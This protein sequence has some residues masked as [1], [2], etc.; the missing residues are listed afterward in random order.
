LAAAVL[1]C[2]AIYAAGCQ[3]ALTINPSGLNNFDLNAERAAKPM[4]LSAEDYNINLHSLYSD[5]GYVKAVLLSSTSSIDGAVATI[6]GT[7]H[8]ISSEPVTDEYSGLLYTYEDIS[9]AIICNGTANIS[10]SLDGEVLLEVVVEP[11]QIVNADKDWITSEDGHSLYTYTG[12]STSVTVPNFYKGKPIRVVGGKYEDEGYNILDNSDSPAIESVSISEGINEIGDYAFC[13]ISSL[14]NA[15]LPNTLEYIGGLSFYETG[16]SGELKLPDKVKEIYAGAFYDT[17]I[18][19]LKLNDGLERICSYSFSYCAKLTGTLELPNSLY[20]LGDCAFLDCYGLS[21]NLIIPSGLTAI[22]GSAFANCTGFNGKLVLKDGVEEIGDMCFAAD[23]GKTMKFTSLELPSTLKHIGAYSFQFCSYIDSLTLPEGLETISDGAFDHMSGITNTSLTIPSTVTTIGGDLNVD[24]NTGYGGHVFY[25]LGKNELFS[26]I[27]VAEGNKYFKSVNGVLYSIDGTR[28]LAYPRGKT[29]TRFEIPEG[30]VQI[31]EMAFSR[32]PYLKTVVLPDSYVI[33][34]EIPKNILNQDGNTLS[35]AIYVYSGVQNIEVKSTNENYKSEDGILYSKDG[36][37]LWYIPP[38]HTGIINV[39]DNTSRIEK[40]AV[41]IANKANI[42]WDSVNIPACV[43][44][45]SEN[46]IEYLNEIGAYVN[47][48]SA[49]TYYVTDD[50]KMVRLLGDINNDGKVDKKDLGAMLRKLAGLS[51]NV[52]G[53]F[54]NEKNEFVDGNGYN[55]ATDDCNRDGM[56][57]IS[58]VIVAIAK[59]G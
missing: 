4:L 18:T 29:D 58:D 5:N 10:I 32:V 41:F 12:N 33:D 35:I 55:D 53:S 11:V 47:I 37:S 9:E 44:Y 30:V 48:D 28:M 36:S 17:A 1:L 19:S 7:E 50:D 27:E 38:K 42:G 46:S 52:D 3:E 16:L 57:N 59:V 54:K 20:Y 24:K 15:E 14:T 2:T 8:T 13:E 45:I 31:D 56:F 51:H 23:S 40:G 43:S 22:G 21:G 39:S 26:S 25:D 34:T 6:N 49:N